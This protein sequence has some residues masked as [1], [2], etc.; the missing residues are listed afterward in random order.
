MRVKTKLLVL[1]LMAALGLWWLAAAPGCLFRNISGIPCPGCGMSRA[2]LAA[3]ELDLKA[4]AAYH[5]LF[6]LLPVVLWLGWTEFR[7]F[8]KSW[9]NIALCAGI[10]LAML[11]C[12]AIRLYF[13]LIP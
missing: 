12:W 13:N 10:V 6:W 4:A 7:P 1:G 2:W 11:V 5:P 3:L 9:R 8:R